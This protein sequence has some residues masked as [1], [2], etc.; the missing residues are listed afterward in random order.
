[1]N[2]TLGEHEIF[3]LYVSLGNLKFNSWGV[4]TKH[5]YDRVS[6]KL[7]KVLANGKTSQS[8]AAF[9]LTFFL[10]ACCP[11]YNWCYMEDIGD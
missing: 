4:L 11:T 5:C 2:C 3:V 9:L 7:G 1:M 6:G 8:M 10:H